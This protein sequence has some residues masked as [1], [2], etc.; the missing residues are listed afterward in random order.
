MLLRYSFLCCCLV[1]SFVRPQTTP[2]I[3]LKCASA[4]SL[5]CIIN[6]LHFDDPSQEL[7]LQDASGRKY[8][9]IKAGTIKAFRTKHCDRFRTFEKVTIGRTGLEELCIA[10]E[11]VQVLAENNHLHTIH[12]DTIDGKDYKLQ[13]LKLSNNRL[14]SVADLCAFHNLRELHLEHN[15]LSTLEMECFASMAQLERLL[16]AGNRINHVNSP[17]SLSLPVLTELGLQNNTLTVLKVAGWSMESLAQLQLASNNLTRVEGLDGLTELSSVSLAGNDWQC[18]ALGSMLTVLRTNEVRIADSDANCEGIGDTSICCQVQESA[19][20]EGE[21]FDELKKYDTLEGKYMAKTR[22]LEDRCKQ[23][24]ANLSKRLREVQQSIAKG[25]EECNVSSEVESSGDEPLETGSGME[26]DQPSGKATATCVRVAP[27]ASAP[28]AP[29]TD[30]TED[31]KQLQDDMRKMRD[32]FERTRKAMD[33]TQRD[34]SLHTKVIRHEMRTAVKR[35]ADKLRDV[36]ARLSMFRAHV[37]DK[38]STIK[39]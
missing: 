24:E 13:T 29:Y 2:E 30:C 19:T 20:A 4:S 21:L 10:R 16:L 8:L 35:G 28:A 32:Q 5:A 3:A 39:K 22:E 38:C 34:L 18:A 27:A 26:P 17:P 33:F 31:L 23:I 6:G 12:P 7:T 36:Q 9:A 25:P 15:L 14:K 37:N 11:F 1:V